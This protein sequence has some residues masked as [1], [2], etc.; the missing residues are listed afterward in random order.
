LANTLV[1]FDRGGKPMLREYG[2][3]RELPVG[4]DSPPWG[5]SSEPIVAPTGDRIAYTL[6]VAGKWQIAVK[7]L[8]GSNVRVLTN[9]EY[10]PRH[11]TWSPDGLF[12][13]FVR[14]DDTHAYSRI[15]RVNVATK[16][17]LQITPGTVLTMHPF[18]A[19]D[20]KIYFVQRDA[21]PV[22]SIRKRNS[23]GTT[24]T[25]VLTLNNFLMGTGMLDGIF[26]LNLSAD[27]EEIYACI[28]KDDVTQIWRFDLGQSLTSEFIGTDFFN[29]FAISPDNRFLLIPQ[30]AGIVKKQ[31][32]GSATSLF[33]N[34][35]SDRSPHWGPYQVART[36]VGNSGTFGTSTGGFIVGQL[37]LITK[38]FVV[39]NAALPE[40]LEVQPQDNPNP[41][42]ANAACIVTGD[43]L[44]DLQYLSDLRGGVVR[45]ITATVNTQATGV[46]ITFDAASGFVAGVIPFSEE[47]SPS[48]SRSSGVMEYS[49]KFLGVYGRD[50]ENK[51][52]GGATSITIDSNSGRVLNWK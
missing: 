49:G 16:A 47:L 38:S 42:Q 9:L 50:G 24:D 5:D 21:G 1:A 27:A 30:S 10:E 43:R 37:G 35:A 48:R 40:T 3:G 39:F 7:N 22:W 33:T 25:L 17:I 36:L 34:D 28:R 13:A 18:W 2:S 51:A 4:T 23:D 11:A 52:P 31:I 45:V 20:G 41:E 19:S 6:L 14:Q 26:D 46:I 12:I 8:D 44:V 29:S 32:R 15:L